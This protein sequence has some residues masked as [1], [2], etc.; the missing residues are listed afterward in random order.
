MSIYVG[1]KKYA[2]YIGDK[3][4]RYM[5]RGGGSYDENSYIQDGLIFQLDGIAK[6]NSGDTSKWV[7]LKGST[8]FTNGGGV[9]ELDNGWYFNATSSSGFSSSSGFL[10]QNENY[11]V[12]VCIKPSTTNNGNRTVFIFSTGSMTNGALFFLSGST[13]TFL[14][15]RNTYPVP[16]VANAPLCVGLNLTLGV[17]NGDVIQKNSG[18]DY[19]DTISLMIGQRNAGA[20]RAYF[21]GTIHAIRIYNRQLTLDE[22]LTNQ[23]IDNTRF[24]L[25]LTI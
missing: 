5:E 9:S 22:I 12:E 20:N 14:Q 25:G 2:P 21:G 18:T 11:T 23:R 13:V 1:D 3:R 17:K 10:A 19:W 16:H 24:E 15:R 7:D 4:R 6:G 8:I